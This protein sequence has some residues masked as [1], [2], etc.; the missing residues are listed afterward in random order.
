[1]P[2]SPPEAELSAPNTTL[3]SL[4][5]HALTASVGVGVGVG[6]GVAVAAAVGED[7]GVR[8]DGDPDVDVPP[9]QALSRAAGSSTRPRRAGR[10]DAPG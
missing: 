2:C 7:A 6:A 10:R 5:V 8:P 9:P 1:M 3:R 4:P